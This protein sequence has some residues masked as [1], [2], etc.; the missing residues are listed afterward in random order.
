L[1]K[2]FEAAG[3]VRVVTTPTVSELEAPGLLSDRALLVPHAAMTVD[4]ATTAPSFVNQETLPLAVLETDP[5][6][7]LSTFVNPL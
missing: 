3:P 1:P 5:R 6:L 7:L 2:K 4:A